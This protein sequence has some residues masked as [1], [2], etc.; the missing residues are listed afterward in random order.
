VNGER[1]RFGDVS[2]DVA[3]REIRR[4][5]ERVALEPKAFDLLV[6]LL[7]EAGAVI[8]KRRLLDEVWADVHVTDGSLARAVTQIRRALGDDPKTPRYVET[9]PTRGSRFIGQLEAGRDDREDRGGVPANEPATS[10]RSLW[11]DAAVLV[12]AAALLAMVAGWFWGPHPVRPREAP[13]LPI[14]AVIVEAATH[15]AVQLTTSRGVDLHPAFSPDGAQLAYASDETGALEIHVRSRVPSAPA[16]PLTTSGGDN[17][18]PA[19]S[20]DGLWIAYHSRRDGGIW[21]VP[22]SGGMPRQLVPEG[23]APAWAPDGATIAFQTAGEADPLG[24]SGGSLSTVALVDV[25][26]GAT[27]PLTVRGAP[28]GSHGRPVW[29]PSGRQIAFVVSR[30]PVAEVWLTSVDGGVQRV[31]SCVTGCRPIVFA[32]GAQHYMAFIDVE[33][34]PGL[35][36]VPLAQDDRPDIA[37]RQ[38]EPLPTSVDV[39]SFAVS[40][41]G[42]YLAYSATVRTS[43]LMEVR[44]AA[45]RPEAVAPPR[46]LIDERRQRYGD[47]MFAPDGATLAFTAVRGGDRPEVFLL[48]VATGALHAATGNGAFVKGWA[49][50]ATSMVVVGGPSPT[51]L[52]RVDVA[53]GRTSPFVTFTRWLSLPDRAQRMF[54]L[55]LSPDLTRYYY[56]AEDDEGLSVWLGD[57]AQARADIRLA[58]VGDGASFGAWASSGRRLAYQVARDWRTTI[59]VQDAQGDAEVRLL[60]T[61]ADHAWVNDWSPDDAWLVMAAMRRGRWTIEAVDAVSGVAHPLTPAAPAAGYVRWPTWSPRGDRIVYERG[62]LSGNIWLATLDDDR[63]PGAGT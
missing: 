61:G 37:G 18:A 51:S 20:P 39:K 17:V 41:D 29:L 8:D 12:T 36:T 43:E 48:D 4:A 30:V 44:L 13:R 63:S 42:R 19:W 59:G 62:S 58:D 10:A 11:R 26:T 7:R 32:R 6:I 15:G 2:L 47:P 3:G 33:P 34:R 52:V 5:G 46:P 55:R 9:V 60:D 31:G 54:T 16:R 14:G 50:D 28:P 45:G 57:T 1:F 21:V 25:R 35:S 38:V 22:S 49:A 56:T 23:A 53:S 40:P 24:G 27:R